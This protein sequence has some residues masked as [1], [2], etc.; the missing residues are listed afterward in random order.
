MPRLIS[1]A[2]L[3]GLRESSNK[4]KKL[5]LPHESAEFWEIYRRSTCAVE[6]RRSQLL[7]FLAVSYAEALRLPGYAEQEADS[8]CLP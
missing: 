3:H 5:T 6:R 1:H 8:R 2:L 4:I 7:A